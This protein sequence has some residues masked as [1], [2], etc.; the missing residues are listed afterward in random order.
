MLTV[1]W[2]IVV[3]AS[4]ID[5]IFKDILYSIRFNQTSIVLRG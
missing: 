3:N 4:N 2:P 5:Q 1:D